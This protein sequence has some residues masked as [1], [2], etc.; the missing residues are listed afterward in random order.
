M[1]T[2]VKYGLLFLVSG[3]IVNYLFRQVFHHIPVDKIILGSDPTGYYQYLPTFFL[4]DWDKFNYLPWAISYGETKWLSVF[5][6]GLAI[7]WSP[8][9]LIAHFLTLFFGLQADGWANLYYGFMVIAALFYVYAGLVFLYKFLREYFEHKTALYTT[10]LMF[11]ATNVFYYTM[12]MGAGMSHAYSFSLICMYLYYVHRFFISPKLKFLI[13]LSLPL[14]LAVL[15]RPTNIIS[16]LL[17]ILYGVNNFR[18]LRERLLFWIKNYYYVLLIFLIG[19][20]VFIPQMLYW[21][22]VT[23]KYIYYSYQEFGFS[24]WLTP[25][26]GV[27][28]FG[29]FNGWLTYT[30][31]VLFALY[32]LFRLIR[33]RELHSIAILVV[34]VC[35]VYINA[36]W[37]VPTFSSALGQRAMIDFMPFIAIPLAWTFNRIDNESRSCRTVFMVLIGLI[38]FYN[39]QFSFRYDP[40]IW[41]TPPFSWDKFFNYLWF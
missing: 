2:I 18:A 26:F 23:G 35:A 11:I 41:W 19:F 33:K 32:G 20:V 14:C 1:K 10:I 37:W 7:L 39:V 34:L 5:T 4:Q 38:I 12:I 13:L 22:T 6:C 28:L 8:F 3:L 25:K 29:K 24:N 16:A 27:V 9:F 31:V 15:I 36:S 17:L 30:P 21:H 40:V